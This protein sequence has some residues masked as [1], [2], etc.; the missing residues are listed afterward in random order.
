MYY[1]IVDSHG[2]EWVQLPNNSYKRLQDKFVILDIE[3]YNHNTQSVNARIRHNQR[4]KKERDLKY[5]TW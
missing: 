5:S 2:Y 1:I 3:H 4:I